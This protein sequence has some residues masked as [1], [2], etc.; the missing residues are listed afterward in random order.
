MK[1]H[2]LFLAM[3]AIA[4]TSADAQIQTQACPNSTF[5]PTKQCYSLDKP[6]ILP[7]LYSAGTYAIPGGEIEGK[8]TQCPVVGD[9]VTDDSLNLQA[10]ITYGKNHGMGI[11][12]PTGNYLITKSENATMLT[13]FRIRGDG[14]GRTNIFHALT[15]PFPVLDFSGSYTSGIQDIEIYPLNGNC[16]GSSATA[17][18]L[19]GGVVGGGGVSG[20]QSY[21][22]KSFVQAGTLAT[23]AAY[24]DSN[25]DLPTIDA[26]SS[27]FTCT[28]GTAAVVGGSVGLATSVTSKFA[29][30]GAPGQLTNA[31]ILGRFV[32]WNITPGQAGPALDLPQSTNYDF[33]DAYA[34]IAGTY[35]FQGI[36]QIDPS[37]ESGGTSNAI[38]CHGLREENNTTSGS[39]VAAFFLN[40][41]SSTNG[42]CTGSFNPGATGYLLGGPPTANSQLQETKF[43]STGGIMAGIT[44]YLTE[45]QN[46]QFFFPSVTSLGTHLPIVVTDSKFV[47][48]LAPQTALV[49]METAAVFGSS[50]DCFS[51]SYN[52]TA[53]HTLC[54]EATYTVSTLPSCVAG[55]V[56]VKANVSDALA[57]TYL[58][59]VTG[60]G[61]VDAPVTCNGTAWVTY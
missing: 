18:I 34:A 60:G 53:T 11:H 10:C 41:L 23:H 51:L 3:L 14:I 27:I 44:N 24:V 19:F 12:L 56:N 59:A 25:G 35:A 8:S 49:A 7:G 37:G 48:N 5:S 52:A 6:L 9:G 38:T 47:L 22:R 57:P 45:L 39:G 61:T 36:I 46:D 21:V 20:S 55:M 32:A 4:F 50:G 26:E 16:A 43:S 15:E 40:N 17:G 2:T 54:T 42:D 13:N 30:L 31:S 58:T 28:G 1:K 29:T 33:G